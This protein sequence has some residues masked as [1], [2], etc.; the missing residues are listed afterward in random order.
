MPSNPNAG[1]RQH[2]RTGPQPPQ[3]PEPSY[4]ERVR[5]LI[6]LSTIGTLSTLSRKREG[7]PF[8]SLM[9]Y[10][11]D[12]AGRPIFLISSMAMHT[13]NLHADPRA[14]L[15]VAQSAADGDPLGAA[16]AT[17]IGEAKPVPESD[18]SAVRD[19][20]IAS[21]ENSKYWVDFSDFSFFRLE[22][23]DIYYVGGFGVMGWVQAQD[24]RQALPD[25]LARASADII[26][27]MNAD[28]AGA[29]ILLARTQAGIEATEA[30]MTAVDRLGF[31]LRLKTPQ[32]MKGV[33]INFPGEVRT[34]QAA[35]EALVEMVRRAK[36][37]S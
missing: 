31:H 3:L 14:S 2:A 35:R 19:L 1:T 11:V 18:T 30:S 17:L 27:H 7:S 20:Y 32:G 12:S 21:H 23:A 8:G 28:H 6:S 10:A 4:A 5:T 9:P 25:P 26:A 33:R 34:S 29:M 24:Y 15:F 16:R 22:L 36:A 13:Q 37:Q